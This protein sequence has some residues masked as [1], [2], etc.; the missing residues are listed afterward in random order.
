MPA[1]IKEGDTAPDFTLLSQEGKDV[2]LHD[3]LGKRNVVLYFYPKDFTMGCTAEAKTFSANYDRLV[4]LGAEVIGVSSDSA[5]SHRGFANEC[6]VKFLLVSDT[7]GRVRDLYGARSSMGLLPGRVT[8]VIDKNGIVR[9]VFSS[10][11]NPRKH[12]EEALDALKA[13]A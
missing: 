2:S 6:G 10:Q 1:R 3:Y 9:K 8:C 7:D 13:L 12:V 11:L 5:G 4:G